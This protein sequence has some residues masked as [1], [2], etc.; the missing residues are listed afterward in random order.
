MCQ[1]QAAHALAV[2]AAH[3]LFA[4]VLS[5]ACMLQSGPTLLERLGLPNGAVRNVVMNND[6]VPRAFACNYQSVANLLAR[7]SEGF[8]G[9]ACLQNPNGRKVRLP[10]RAACRAIGRFLFCGARPGRR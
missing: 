5:H 1:F 2:Q 10:E 9:H 4:R 3:A 8:R 6:I 7:V